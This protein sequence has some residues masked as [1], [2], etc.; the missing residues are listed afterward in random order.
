MVDLYWISN[1][2]PTFGRPPGRLIGGVW[3]GGCPPRNPVKFRLLAAPGQYLFIDWVSMRVGA[4]YEA[5]KPLVVLQ[6][7]RQM[8]VG[9]QM[10][11]MLLCNVLTDHDMLLC[12]VPDMLSGHRR[13]M[14][15]RPF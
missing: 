14:W 1:T 6:E 11:D 3:G 5:P 10:P 4:P 12:N 15:P 9:E 2:I 13:N 8:P 7:L